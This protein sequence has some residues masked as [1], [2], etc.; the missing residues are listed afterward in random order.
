[1]A[2]CY[3]L[4]NCAEF[5]ASDVQTHIVCV[6]VRVCIWDQLTHDFV[7]QK[8]R[9]HTTHNKPMTS[10]VCRAISQSWVSR[11]RTSV[12]VCVCVCVIF[13]CDFCNVWFLSSKLIV[14]YISYLSF[15][16]NAILLIFFWNKYMISKST[17]FYIEFLWLN[18]Q[19]HSQGRAWV[20]DVC[21]PYECVGGAP[22]SPSPFQTRWTYP[23]Y[24]WEPILSHP[25]SESLS[26]G[27][28]VGPGVI[29][30]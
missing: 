13:L 23:L 28:R 20:H 25:L 18:I 7:T 9:K 30:E 8:R 14:R 11:S 16:Y 29:V 12:C 19:W 2:N 17:I 24:F 27:T 1:M 26:L 21:P 3:E 4:V 15:L 10:W 5:A 6:C 22:A